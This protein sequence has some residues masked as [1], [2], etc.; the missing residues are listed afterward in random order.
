MRVSELRGRKGGERRGEERRLVTSL[1]R[2]RRALQSAAS[3]DVLPCSPPSGPPLCAQ[4]A[5]G[6]VTSERLSG[7]YLSEEPGRQAAG[8][9]PRRSCGGHAAALWITR[10]A[11]DSLP[12]LTADSSAS[13]NSR[14]HC[15]ESFHLSAWLT[16][17]FPI[18]RE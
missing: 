18:K 14:A 12:A 15:N 17:D 9:A 13:R 6:S 11:E 1:R 5:L 3:F 10:A 7:L 16:V 4:R 8:T 2:S